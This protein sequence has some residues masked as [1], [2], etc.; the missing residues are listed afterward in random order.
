[1]AVG[2]HWQMGRIFLSA[3]QGGIEQTVQNSGI[4]P[5]GTTATQEMIWVRDL[6]AAELRSRGLT[7]Y[8]V[9]DDLNPVARI[10]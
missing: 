9:G 10:D 6:V 7:V 3:G 2:H 8:S 4:I 5:G 1:M